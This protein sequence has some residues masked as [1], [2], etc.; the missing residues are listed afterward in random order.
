MINLQI[1]IDEDAVR[2]LKVG[3]EVSLSG[4]VV[5]ARDAA[6]KLMVEKRP[7]FIRPYLHESAFLRALKL[8]CF[9]GC[10]PNPCLLYNF[11][12]FIQQTNGH[13]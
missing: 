8:R 11:L 10:K 9:L 5:T 1:P 7:D 6:H 13:V 12:I 4:T 2:S 3:D